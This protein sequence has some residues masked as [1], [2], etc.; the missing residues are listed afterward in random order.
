MSKK[1]LTT[2]VV[3]LVLVIGVYGAYRVYKHFKRVSAPAAAVA[4]QTSAPTTNALSNLKDL[5]SKGIAQSCT[6]SS[7]K[8]QGTVY[9]SGGK[10]RADVDTMVGSVSTKAHMIISGGMMYLWTDGRK[11]GM[12]MSYNVNVTPAPSTA[13][14]A[15]ASGTLDANASMNYK[16]GVWLA[17]ASMFAPPADVSFG[18]F[19]M[20]TSGSSST[21]SLCSNC[22]N[23]T[24]N[25]KTQCLAALK[26]N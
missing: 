12:K 4:T 8:S 3:L 23:L 2:L 16:C 22:N 26:C 19:A 5:I 24:G 18:T 10:A 13:P 21:S 11:V 7:D 17:D 6:F 25:D 15:G 14:S 9:M 20:P 1:A